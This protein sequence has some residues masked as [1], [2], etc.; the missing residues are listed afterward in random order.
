MLLFVVP[1]T[2]LGATLNVKSATG[3]VAIGSGCSDECTPSVMSPCFLVCDNATN[4]LS[5]FANVTISISPI[6][7]DSSCTADVATIGGSVS[8]TATVYYRI[9]FLIDAPTAVYAAWNVFFP[10][11]GNNFLPKQLPENGNWVGIV[12]AGSYFIECFGDVAGDEVFSEGLSIRVIPDLTA[13]CDSDGTPD[14]QEIIDGT[15]PDAN[16]NGIPDACEVRIDP[17]DLN[18]DGSVNAADLALLLGAWGTAGPGDID[19]D[20]EVTAADLALMLGSWT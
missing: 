3:M 13:D 20:G 12:Q 11:A 4:E 16:S 1:S 15:Q 9:D 7:I 18:A 19:G 14:W 5:E 8:P 2:A 6:S 17:A 10:P